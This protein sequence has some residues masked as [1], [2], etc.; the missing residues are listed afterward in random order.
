MD[1]TELKMIRTEG[2]KLRNVLGMAASDR[3]A[4][5]S[6]LAAA[7]D[8]AGITDTAMREKIGADCI[9]LAKQAREGEGPFVLHQLA[10]QMTLG[11]LKA[12]HTGDSLLGDEP[13]WSDNTPD[14]TGADDVMDRVRH[15]HETDEQRAARRQ[16][17]AERDRLRALGVNV[18]G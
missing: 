6:Q 8:E 4:T 9:A 12:M 10:D 11:H 16:A 18:G 15:P 17:D 13:D 2:A 14:E 7:L 1:R 5:R 3:P